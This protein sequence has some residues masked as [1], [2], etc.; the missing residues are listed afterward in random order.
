MQINLRTTYNDGTKKD[1]TAV[2]V[3]LVAFETK[4][5]LSIARLEQNIKLTHLF[6]LAYHIEKRT[7]GTTEEFEKWLESVEGIEAVAPKK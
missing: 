3:D 6:F 7:G 4:F 1:L 2:A 5:D